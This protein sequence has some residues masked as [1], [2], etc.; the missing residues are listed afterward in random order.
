MP[1]TSFANPANNVASS[2]S[3][4]ISA[5]SSSI[6]LIPNGGAIFPAAPFY[7]SCEF[8][9]M[10]CV[11]KKGDTLTVNRGV[12]GTIAAQHPASALI[13]IR[14]NAALWTDAYSAINSNA[15]VVDALT[16]NVYS[17]AALPP[18]VVYKDSTQ[19]LTHKTIDLTDASK[20]NQI[21][22]TVT[23]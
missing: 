22:G 10:Y 17:G 3:T 2:L 7:C 23:P 16:Q 19:E 6:P 15:A 21:I 11:G 9:V 12:D 18:N 5:G 8:E 1:S 14:N 20:G 4:Q 13:E